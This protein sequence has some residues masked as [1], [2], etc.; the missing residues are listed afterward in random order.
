LD[1]WADGVPD[2][3]ASNGVAYDPDYKNWQSISTTDAYSNGTMRVIVGNAIAIK[4]IKENNT[5]HWP[6]GPVLAKIQWDQLADKEGNIHPGKFN[7]V[8]FMV[9]VPDDKDVMFASKCIS[10]HRPVKDYAYVYGYVPV[11]ITATYPIT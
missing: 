9:L 4:A 2:W 6:D 8:E 5:R 3:S 10:C 7:E 11:Q 1:S